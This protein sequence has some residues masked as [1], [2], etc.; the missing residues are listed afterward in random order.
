MTTTPAPIAG[1]EHTAP[2]EEQVVFSRTAGVVA[3]KISYVDILDSAND[4]QVLE[5]TVSGND[6]CG[7]RVHL[8]TVINMS[9]RLSFIGERSMYCSLF[10][11]LTGYGI[12]DT[13]L[14]YA[15][16]SPQRGT[17]NTYVA[18]FYICAS[19][20]TCVPASFFE[21]STVN[22]T[23]THDSAYQS[24][25]VQGFAGTR[26]PGRLEKDIISSLAFFSF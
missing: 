6:K 19:L 17:K 13:R 1:M 14:R 10:R 4:W 8:L 15:K 12:P 7:P 18:C 16:R 9:T 24:T 21:T 22:R 26:I 5:S 23:S 25:V 3:S 11:R 2:G 20:I